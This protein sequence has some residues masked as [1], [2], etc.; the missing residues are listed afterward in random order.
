MRMLRRMLRLAE[1]TG[2]YLDVT[3]LAC[4]RTADIPKWYDDLDDAGR[5]KAQAA[6]WEAVASECAGSPA[7]FCYDLMN[8]PMAPAGKREK[9]NWMSGKPFGGYDFVQFIALD[10]GD[11]RREDIPVEWIRQLSAAIHRRDRKHLVTVGLLPWMR[12]WKHL[13]GFVPERVAPELDFLSVHLYPDTKRP[14]EALEA[15]KQCDAGKPVV[16]EETFQLSC[17]IIEL[18]EFLRATPSIA[19]GWIGHYDGTSIEEADAAERA[20]KLDDKQAAYREFLRLFV[21]LEPVLRDK[22]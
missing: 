19:C 11:R 21:R 15:L 13:S 16:I 2:I 9:G 12:D 7:V 3:G 17:S 8:E 14:G 1:Q 20:G 6:F 4:Y 22:P 18:E 5:W 10:Q